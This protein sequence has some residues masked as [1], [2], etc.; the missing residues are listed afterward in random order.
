MLGLVKSPPH[1]LFRIATRVRTSTSTTHLRKSED[2]AAAEVTENGQCLRR[3]GSDESVAR[4]VRQQTD[5]RFEQGK[6][7]TDPRPRRRIEFRILNSSFADRNSC[8]W[9]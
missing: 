8:A 4:Y 6:L 5:C 1:L 9:L 3:L 2:K 7:C